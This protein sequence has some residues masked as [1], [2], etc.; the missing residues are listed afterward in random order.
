[1]FVNIKKSIIFA[2]ILKIKNMEENKNTFE[3]GKKYNFSWCKIN[4]ENKFIHCF[5]ETLVN[6][7]A[8]EDLSSMI[9]VEMYIDETGII[10]I[11]GNELIWKFTLHEI[12]ID[13]IEEGVYDKSIK[14]YDGFNLF[15]FIKKEPYDY[16][17]GWYAIKKTIKVE[18]ALLWDKYTIKFSE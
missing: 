13:D 12:N 17:E 9:N 11:S 16:V 2:E 3:I 1:M 6:Y 7:N 15:G 5:N 8:G 18:Y 4:Q 10:H 14:H